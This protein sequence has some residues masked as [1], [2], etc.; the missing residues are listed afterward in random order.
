MTVKASTAAVASQMRVGAASPGRTPSP[1]FFREKCR[2]G[3]SPFL[4]RFAPPAPS[5][6][7][8]AGETPERGRPPYSPKIW[9]KRSRRAA[10]FSVKS[11]RFSSTVLMSSTGGAPSGTPTDGSTGMYPCSTKMR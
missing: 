2:N 4:L 1:R 8:G 7:G 10:E 5:P 9:A 3:P 11:F 6:K